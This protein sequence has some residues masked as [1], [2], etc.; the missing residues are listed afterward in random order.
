MLFT[1]VVL[2]P[3]QGTTPE[4]GLF[5]FSGRL[6]L[7]LFWRSKKK[8]YL[9]GNQKKSIVGQNAAC[10]AQQRRIHFMHFYSLANGFQQHN[11]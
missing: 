7:F 11:G 5:S 1:T 4:N 9:Y 8:R 10:F 3:N 2:K 6:F